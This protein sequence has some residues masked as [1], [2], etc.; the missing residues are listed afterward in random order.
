MKIRCKW[1]GAVHEVD[2]KVTKCMGCGRSMKDEK[3]ESEELLAF[4]DGLEE[5]AAEA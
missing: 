5:K 2:F 4:L 1:C 3:K